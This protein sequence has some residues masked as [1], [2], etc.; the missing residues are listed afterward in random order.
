MAGR[1]SPDVEYP[2]IC[3]MHAQ[4]IPANEGIAEM[5]VPHVK[6]RT[7]KH[8]ESNHVLKSPEDQVRL[9][10]LRAP[11]I[12]SEAVKKAAFSKSLILEVFLPC[13]FL[14]REI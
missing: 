9:F 11:R 14:E 3:S 12:D 5:K 8:S 10:T 2:P 1:E 6:P 7:P 4:F 13:P